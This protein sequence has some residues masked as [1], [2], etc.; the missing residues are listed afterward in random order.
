MVGQL[1]MLFTN[2]RINAM[3]MNRAE[4]RELEERAMRGGEEKPPQPPQGV[5]TFLDTEDEQKK[6]P[7]MSS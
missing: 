4:L 5:P 7:A 1:L 3:C 2:S 6:E